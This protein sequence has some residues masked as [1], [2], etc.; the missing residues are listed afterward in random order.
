MLAFSTALLLGI[1]SVHQAVACGR[2]AIAP[3]PVSFML[4]LATIQDFE[5]RNR[6]DACDN[7]NS[8]DYFNLLIERG[9]PVVCLTRFF[10][11]DCIKVHFD[12]PPPA[13]F[14]T[15]FASWI[16]LSH[17]LQ[18]SHWRSRRDQRLL[19]VCLPDPRPIKAPYGVQATPIS[20]NR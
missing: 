2:F 7:A 17:G 9:F 1:L 13:P 15:R 6:N 18:C 4:L 16:R 19:Y 12:G 5:S 20:K 11:P 8:K 10:R 3:R 14:Q